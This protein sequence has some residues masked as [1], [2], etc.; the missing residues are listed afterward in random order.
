MKKIGIGLL[1]GLLLL[2]VTT[3]CWNRRELNTL[4]IQ[5]G[6]GIDKVGNQYRLSVQVVNPG[7]VAAGYNSA[8]MRSPVTLY[9]AT[10]PTLFE[11]F[12]KLTTLSPRKVYGAHIRVL[13]LGESLA[14]EGV[15]KVLDLLSR[16]AENRT[17]F[18]IMI[19]RRNTAE[20]TLKVL[21]LLEKIPSNKL[22]SSLDASSHAWAPTT[23]FTLD[24]LISQLVTEGLNPVLTGVQ[25]QGDPRIGETPKNVEEIEPAT[26]LV[27]SDLAVFHKARMIGW[28]NEQESRG[29][30]LIMNNVKSTAASLTCPGGGKL[31][32]EVLRNNTKI[33]GHVEDG[34]PS[35]NIH[36]KT[37]ANIAE[38]NCE[39]DLDNP[40]TIKKVEEQMK[41]TAFELMEK[42]VE[43]AQN[44]YK[45]DIF[46]F[47]QAIF[48]SNPK[49]WDQVSERW[50]EKFVRLKVNYSGV[51]L[52]RRSGTTGNTFLK[53]IK[54]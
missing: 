18:Y 45:T 48:R 49:Y 10:A 42:S 33:K 32:V 15:D 31:T 1:C 17:D 6:T 4:A 34:E 52:I 29:Y 37:E 19:A 8:T 35:I 54:R 53:D 23:A 20:N 27:L 28:L 3:G 24:Q 38:V 16:D 51:C 43:A 2:M 46:G 7:Q 22:Y 41:D 5:L 9:A 50:T 44:R 40:V 21:T 36:I 26:R 14:R 39:I 11:A 47:G 13:I 12:R 30:N 25:I